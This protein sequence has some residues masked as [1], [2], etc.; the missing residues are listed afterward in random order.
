[1]DDEIIVFD[2]I[3]PQY[4]ADMVE[5]TIFGRYPLV[6]GRHNS[7]SP[8]LEDKKN[9][10]NL[11][12]QFQFN[13][14]SIRNG[15][16]IPI[17]KPVSEIVMTPLILGLPKIN[18]YPTLMNI[19]RCKVNVQTKAYEDV[20][21]RYNMPHVDNLDNQNILT[22]IYYVND[23]DGDTIIFNEKMV[24]GKVLSSNEVNN[25]TIKKKISPK[26]GRIL[27][28]PSEFIHAGIHPQNSMMRAVINYNYKI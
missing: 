10:T 17:F 21:N 5:E 18:V 15:K 19:M 26:K 2:N 27:I 1:M 12:E 7:T 14:N 24:E 3:V 25:L 6:V 22:I 13:G 23:A 11:Y 9:Y 20:R 16:I 4:F 8:V 28:F